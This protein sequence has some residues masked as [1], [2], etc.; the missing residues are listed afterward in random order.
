MIVREEEDVLGKAPH[1]RIL[2]DKVMVLQFG[3]QSVPLREIKVR[4]QCNFRLYNIDEPNKIGNCW[5]HTAL[6][7]YLGHGQA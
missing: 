4:L 6:D 3:I 5:P 7:I 2:F 1:G